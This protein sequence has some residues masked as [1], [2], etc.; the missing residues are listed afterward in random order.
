[1]RN[2]QIIWLDSDNIDHRKLELIEMSDEERGIDATESFE[3]D[4]NFR[5]EEK[6]KEKF[7]K[8]RRGVINF[9]FKNCR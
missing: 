3:A 6:G 4:F 5:F 7:I 9:T 1:M 8:N 2:L